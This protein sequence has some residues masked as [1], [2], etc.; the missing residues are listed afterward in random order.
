MFT[1][2]AF[3]DVS[4]KSLSTY[5]SAE[6]YNSIQVYT[7]L[8]DYSGHT[9]NS[10]GWTLIFDDYVQQRGIAELT[11][12]GPFKGGQRIDIPA[13]GSASFYVYTTEKLSYQYQND[14]V[15]GKAVT[16]DGSVQL[17]AGTAFAY[18]KWKNGCSP[19]VSPQPNSQCVFSPRVF[20]GL[21]EYE[22][23]VVA[24]PQPTPPPTPPPVPKPTPNVSLTIIHNIRFPV[25]RYF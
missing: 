21:V 1:L 6:V 9:S 14:W 2:R 5:T 8:G 10:E 19:G 12:L 20:S 18:G 7:R 22:R 23:S 4:V 13:G 3:R 25:L 11:K 15:E 17:L 16:D 24:T